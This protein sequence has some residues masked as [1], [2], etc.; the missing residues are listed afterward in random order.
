MLARLGIAI[1]F[2]AGFIQ[3]LP[4]MAG[5]AV[6]QGKQRQEHS[7]K[8]NLVPAV[9]LTFFLLTGC[10]ELN[11][12]IPA[13]RST[14]STASSSGLTNDEIIA[15]LKEALSV[16]ATNSTSLASKTDGFNLNSFI[17]IPFP[18]EA[19]K[20]RDAAVKVG[21]TNLVNDFETS[22]NRAAE[23]AAKT[24]LPIF[25]NAVF[26]MTISDALGILRGSNYAATEYL[27]SRTQSALVTEFSPIVNRAI[28]S[29]NV[30]KYWSPLASAYNKTT[31][32]TGGPQVNP[33]LDQYVTQK[34][35]DGLFYLIGQEEQKIRVNP[36]ARVTEILRK[37][38][39]A[40]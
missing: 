23:E 35:L 34:A 14:L 38:F 12:L 26:S 3:P 7:M 5:N 19:V 30:T 13:V 32:L 6:R 18:P 20:V 40:K 22:L 36:A 39:G 28:Q 8:K 31:V 25:K 9:A 2:V 10:A 27:K 33:N 17:R 24:A 4:P 16:G 15:G 37:V 1:Y 29:V 21:L 11:A